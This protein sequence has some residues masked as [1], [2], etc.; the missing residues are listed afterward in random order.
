[1]DGKVKTANECRKENF[2]QIKQHVNDIGDVNDILIAG[3]H[4]QS[5]ASKEISKFHEDIRFDDV[6]HKCNNM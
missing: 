1:M 6:H 2:H 4:N 3:D 5:A